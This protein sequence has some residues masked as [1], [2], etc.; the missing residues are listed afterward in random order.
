MGSGQLGTARGVNSAKFSELAGKVTCWKTGL[1]QRAARTILGRLFSRPPL[2]DAYV[3]R[4]GKMVDEDFPEKIIE[5]SRGVRYRI[6]AD[7]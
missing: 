3:Q 1:F 5:T 6:L 7:I 2:A 4:S